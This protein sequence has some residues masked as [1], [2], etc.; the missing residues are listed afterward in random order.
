MPSLDEF[1][2]AHHHGLVA[3]ARR[4]QL[5]PEGGAVAIPRLVDPPI[6]REVALITLRDQKLSP[7]ADRFARLIVREVRAT[8]GYDAAAGD[9]AG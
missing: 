4:L 7:A 1:E 9:A 6:I 5:G 8:T 3:L 2:L